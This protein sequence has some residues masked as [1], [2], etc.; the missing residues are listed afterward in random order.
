MAETKAR[1][2]KRREKGRYLN[3][4]LLWVISLF[5]NSSPF[6]KLFSFAILL[7]CLGSSEASYFFLSRIIRSVFLIC[8]LKVQIGTGSLSFFSIRVIPEGS[9]YMYR[10]CLE[11]EPFVY[12]LARRGSELEER[13]GQVQ[14]L[15]MKLKK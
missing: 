4:F 13:V 9:I 8:I 5:L 7:P 12:R 15:S 10:E 6:S 11:R 1:S 14:S 2:G 3:S